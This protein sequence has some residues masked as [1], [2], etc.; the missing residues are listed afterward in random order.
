MK[1]EFLYILGI[2][3]IF[4]FFVIFLKHL[5]QKIQSALMYA[6]LNHSKSSVWINKLLVEFR[7]NWLN[8]IQQ[9][10]PLVSVWLWAQ[11]FIRKQHGIMR[12]QLENNKRYLFLKWTLLS[13]VRSRWLSRAR[14]VIYIRV[15]WHSFWNV[16]LPHKYLPKHSTTSST[17]M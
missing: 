5:Q 7:T 1:L 10:N 12:L 13:L 17:A 4:S 15:K 3:T 6:G 2:R 16:Y 8:L 9:Y 11:Y 14:L